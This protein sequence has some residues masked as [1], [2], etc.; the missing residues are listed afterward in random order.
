MLDE[1]WVDVRT[2]VR[3]EQR[4]A[5]GYGYPGD[6]TMQDAVAISYRQPPP[7]PPDVAAGG[8]VTPRWWR[9]F[10]QVTTAVSLLV[11]LGLWLTGGSLHQLDTVRGAIVGVGRL[12]GLLSADLL[13]F[14][15]V[16]MA[17]IPL[18]E[19]AYGQDE[20]T[21]RHRLI[22][23]WSFNLLLVHIVMVTYGE[24]VTSLAGAV[25]QFVDYIAHGS[26]MLLATAA[27]ALLTLVVAMS[28]RAARR[29]LRYEAWHLIH[30]YAYLGVGLSVPHEL[31]MGDDFAASPLARAYWWT[32]YG[33]AL[34]AVLI[35]RVGR[36]F[37]RSLRHRLVVDRVVAEG[38]GVVSVH[39]RGRKL[40]RLGAAA[41]QFFTWRFLDGRGWTEGH[42]FSLSAAPQPDQLRIT[43]KDLGDGSGQLAGLRPGTRVMIEGPYGRLH[44]GVRT[45]RK[46]TL[47]AAGI[48]ITPMRAL[49]EE[50]DAAPGDLTLIYRAGGP[51][52]LV[53]TDEINQIAAGRGAQVYYVMGKRRRSRR[54]ASWLP[55]AAVGL[56]DVEALRQL[57]PTIEQ[58]DVYL[59]GPDLWLAAVR[60]AVL[61]AG[62]PAEQVHTERFAW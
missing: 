56:S 25:G 50:L 34:A 26:G 31:A 48:G 52:E 28:V 1:R 7:R 27:T 39:I 3:N 9:E 43:V 47:L 20:L 62:V 45:R 13:L 4:E 19:R 49:L 51:D 40:D 36:P 60:Q 22:G 14:Q 59:C 5:V 23:F 42:P 38:P 18:V 53:F 15:V 10:V 46:V 24:I 55:D 21:R 17:R 58:Q 61:R 12:A 44:A 6:P 8:R 57:V 54:G 16:M 35:W 41:G 33:A 30:L 32:L 11:V 29:R 37:A 2:T